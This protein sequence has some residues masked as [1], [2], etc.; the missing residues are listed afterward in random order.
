MK[1]RMAALSIAFAF[2]LTIALGICPVAFAN[3]GALGAGTSSQLVTEQEVAPQV[4]APQ[5]VKWKTISSPEQLRVISLKSEGFGPGYYKLGADFSLST[6][7][8]DPTEMTCGIING[9]Y[10]IDFNGHTVQSACDRFGVFRIA[11]ANVTFL[12]SKA[13]VSKPSVNS[14]GIGC[15]EVLNKGSL[16]I[17][18]GTYDASKSY[19]DASALF[20]GNGSCTV[21]GGTFAGS[22]VAAS[23]SGGNLRINGGRFSGGYPYALLHM[24][25]K[26]KVARGAFY[27]GSTVQNA[28]FAIGVFAL[29][30]S[31]TPQYV[32]MDALLAPKSSWDTPFQTV[33]YNGQSTLSPTPSIM[34]TMAASYAQTVIVNGT[35]GA[36]KS[37]AVSAPTLKSV[38]AGKGKAT[39][40]WG[41]VPGAAKYQL[42]YSTAKN[43]KGAKTVNA[44]AKKTSTTLKKL[45]PGTRYYVQVRVFKKISGLTYYSAWSPKKSA[46][47]L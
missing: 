44:S 17:L 42:R 31:G 11:N 20:V 28:T 27:S 12:D 22:Y 41:K 4:M 10:V 16:T 7:T 39:A 35:V 8:S 25:G 3:E 1:T 23:N 13:S 38:Q 29:D 21:N 18:N 15:I 43:M 33:Y 45:K 34:T 30:A 36:Q 47:M 14:L 19:S 9:T 32:N 24:A 2:V 46:V 26:T 6:D 37:A 5:A 40:T